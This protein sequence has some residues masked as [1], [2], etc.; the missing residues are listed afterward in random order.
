MNILQIIGIVLRH[1]QDHKSVKD[2]LEEAEARTKRIYTNIRQV[3]LLP[4]VESVLSLFINE[5]V[6]DFERICDE[7]LLIQEKVTNRTTARSVL[8]SPATLS[9]LKE[10]LSR[11]KQKDENIKLMG[12]IA[13]LEVGLQSCATD[14]REGFA[15]VLMELNA[16]SEDLRPVKAMLCHV[17]RTQLL[18]SGDQWIEEIDSVDKLATGIA[19][20]EGSQSV[21]KDLQKAARYLNAA[22]N[23]GNSEAYYY[24]GM[25]YRSGGGVE[26]CNITAFKYFEKGTRSKDPKSMA[27]LSACYWYGEGVE[28]SDPLAVAYAKMSAEAGDPY[29]M[30]LRAEH[31][32]Y[33]TI[34]GRNISVAFNLS[35]KAFEKG[36]KQAK[37]QLAA[38]YFHGLTVEQDLSTAIQFWIECVEDGGYSC[39]VDLASCYERG[40]GVDVDLQKAAELYKMGSEITSDSWRRYH[41]Q[42]FYGLC[43]LRGRGVKQDVQTGWSL[44][45]GSIQSNKD[46]GW[47]AQGECYRHGYGVTKNMD[48]AI[49]SYEKAIGV[50]DF[51][52]GKYL[53]HHALGSMY[54]HGEGLERDYS[55]AFEHYNS[56]AN[57]L[58]HEAEWKVALWCES[59]IGVEKDI[60]RAVAYFRLAANGGRRDAQIKSYHYYMEGKGVQRNLMSSAQVIEAAAESGDKRAKRLLRRLMRKRIHFRLFNSSRISI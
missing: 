53:A 4:G 33:G 57:F 55:K 46:T 18:N 58:I 2:V 23:A 8:A 32:L 42:A 13:K 38:C 1:V 56:S 48:L 26:K 44:I 21:P 39:I 30:Y 15:K 49:R 51:A 5:T 59:G 12:M 52:R 35:K 28:L 19:F 9:D 43:L 50:V 36:N 60:A 6:E 20:Y 29:G 47:F 45:L 3:K 16:Q 41:I 11:L 34:T 25:L 7:L 27:Q 24:L 17:C 37:R 31:T 54:E 10:I 40:L 22:L 14:I